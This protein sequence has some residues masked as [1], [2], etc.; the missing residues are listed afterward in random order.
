MSRT[1]LGL[2]IYTASDGDIDQEALHD[3]RILVFSLEEFLHS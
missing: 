1:Q 2:L 3:P